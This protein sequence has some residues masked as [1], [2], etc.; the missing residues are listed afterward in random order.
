VLVTRSCRIAWDI[1]H[2][3]LQSVRDNVHAVPLAVATRLWRVL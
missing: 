2:G 3:F 1:H